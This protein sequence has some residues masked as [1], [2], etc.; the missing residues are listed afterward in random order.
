MIRSLQLL[1]LTFF[2]VLL[3]QVADAQGYCTT[4][5]VSINVTGEEAFNEYVEVFKLEGG[6]LNK[7]VK[8]IP[9]VIHIIY[10]NAADST[11][12]SMTR[13]TNVI[14]QCNT[15]LR[16]LNADTF[17]T[18]VEFKNV[19]ADCQ[20]QVCLVT[21]KP[22]QSTFNGVIYHHQPD[23]NT[24]SDYSNFV[25][26]NLL[27]RSKYLN[28]FITPEEHNGSAV[29]P[30]EANNTKD[31][32]YVGSE[33]FGVYEPDMQ[34]WG[35]QGTTFTHEL[36]HYLGVYHTF[37]ASAF[38]AYQCELAHD[39]TIGDK[40]A[41]TPLEWDW[42]FSGDQC[43]DGI[44]PCND[45]TQT[46]QT[47]TENYMYYNKDSCTNM[48]SMDQRARMR[49]CLYDLRSNLVSPENATFTG[50]SCEPILSVEDPAENNS[51]L[52]K[53]I[54]IY[55][56]PA[57]NRINCQFLNQYSESTIWIYDMLG[58]IKDVVEMRDGQEE[59]QIDIS[60]Y[61]PGVYITIV[62]IDKQIVGKQKF[63]KQ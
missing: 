24:P 40:C 32:F 17:N 37:H 55:P 2:S 53:A 11:K 6:A 43:N 36:A 39:P 34:N 9:T 5:E 61:S 10:R 59:V 50:I 60:D 35:I 20:I 13:I 7:D 25:S 30:W 21:K 22:D 28:V 51:S 14:N 49:A 57:S 54:N 27:D 31:G 23:W 62:K 41:D 47:Q 38:Y 16:R 29:L 1:L 52:D 33:L 44:R 45:T 3:N 58:G 4:P 19:A 12:M 42:P 48:L 18:R 8:I 46:L 63:V 15:Q 26:N 56:N